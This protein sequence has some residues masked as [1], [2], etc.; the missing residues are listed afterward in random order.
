MELGTLYLLL[1]TLDV[2]SNLVGVA[3]YIDFS[4]ADE[5]NFAVQKDISFGSSFSLI[6]EVKVQG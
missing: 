3:P 1:R 6:G 4:L 5:S 2:K